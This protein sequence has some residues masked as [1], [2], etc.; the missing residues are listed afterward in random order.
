MHAVSTYL[1]RTYLLRTRDARSFAAVAVCIAPRRR[2]PVA[3]PGVSLQRRR[4]LP[5]WRQGQSRGEGYNEPGWASIRKIFWWGDG[6]RRGRTRDVKVVR[7]GLPRQVR[8]DSVSSTGGGET[9]APRLPLRPKTSPALSSSGGEAP[10][11]RE[12]PRRP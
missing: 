1:L 2:S 5:T 7:A 12:Q 6:D 10:A 11:R 8:E 9:P 3:A 4:R